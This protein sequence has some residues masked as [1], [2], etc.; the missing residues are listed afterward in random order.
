MY[1]ACLMKTAKR[2]QL[3]MHDVKNCSRNVHDILKKHDDGNL[4]FDHNLNVH[5]YQHSITEVAAI[6]SVFWTLKKVGIFY[7]PLIIHAK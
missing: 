2:Y 1:K 6:E 7:I 4:T 3:Q 5:D